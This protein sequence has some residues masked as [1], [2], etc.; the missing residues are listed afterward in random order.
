MMI[1]QKPL[2]YTDGGRGTQGTVHDDRKSLTL[3]TSS[4]RSL[5][6]AAAAVLLPLFQRLSTVSGHTLALSDLL[7]A[8]IVPRCGGI[9]AVHEP[10]YKKKS[11][12]R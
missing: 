6:A 4:R 12:Y 8:L 11:E 1:L 9:C 7:G 10:N 3:S 2:A 5:V